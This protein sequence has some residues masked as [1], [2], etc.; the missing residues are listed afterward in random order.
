MG[1]LMASGGLPEHKQG[2]KG[3]TPSNSVSSPSRESKQTTDQE[4]ITILSRTRFQAFIIHLI[5]H[6]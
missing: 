4:S 1:E 5:F 3:I 6:E 2:F